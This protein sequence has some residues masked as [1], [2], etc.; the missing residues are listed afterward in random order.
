MASAQEDRSARAAGGAAAVSRRTFIDLVFSGGIVFTI[1]VSLGVIFRFLWPPKRGSAGSEKTLVGELDQIPVGGSV[2][3]VVGGRGV[4]IIRTGT[5]FVGLGLRCTHKGCNVEW[6]P[7]RRAVVCPCHGG[8]FDLQ[9]N[10]LGGPP[11]RP[12]DRFKVKVVGDKV[13]VED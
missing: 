8:S 4:L 13:Y 12:L 11:P 9:G 5:G 6:D 1:L 7:D 3:R 2:R 10:V